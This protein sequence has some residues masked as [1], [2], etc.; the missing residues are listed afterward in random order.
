M[1]NFLRFST[2]LIAMTLA[3][4]GASVPAIKP[5]KIEIQQGNVVTSEMLL[6]LRPGMTKSQVQFIMG[7]PLLVDS[8]HSNRWDY[9]YQLRKQGEIV[10]QRRVILDFEKDLL[11]RVRGDVVPKGASVEDVTKQLETEAAKGDQSEA[12]MDEA[13]K[14]AEPIVNPIEEPDIKPTDAAPESSI[15]D[16]A[17]TDD[18]ENAESNAP[19]SVLVVP[20]G[21][22]PAGSSD[23]VP[24]VDMQA[25]DAAP[26]T[27]RA[28]PSTPAGE[29]TSG[30][31]IV[32][33][34]DAEKSKAVEE[35]KKP[36]P[37]NNESDEKLIFRLDRQLDD[38]RIN[39]QETA[40]RK[41]LVQDS[42]VKEIKEEAPP[43]EEEPG[44]F[45]RILEKIG[46]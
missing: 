35:T 31:A 32:P 10:S 7:T 21:A 38:S 39:Q 6:K 29:Q 23:L 8:F 1:R 37:I 27:D 40:P 3:A 12:P 44:V 11:V 9:F 24:K 34:S 42:V 5:Y 28:E 16:Q 20:I 45:E 17:S 18:S 33:L 15:K 46:F 19:A 30:S 2:L 4:C 41:P 26:V 14:P 25:E 13:D 22:Q 43:N 36:A